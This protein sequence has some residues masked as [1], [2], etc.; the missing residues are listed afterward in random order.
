M[1][2]Y[3]F[4]IY[5]PIFSIYNTVCQSTTLYFNTRPCIFHSLN[6]SLSHAHPHKMIVYTC[7]GNRVC[8]ICAHTHACTHTGTAVCNICIFVWCNPVYLRI[9]MHM[10]VCVRVARAHAHQ[11]VQMQM[12][13]ANLVVFAYI[14]MRVCACACV[15]VHVC[16]CVCVCVCVSVYTGFVLATLVAPMGAMSLTSI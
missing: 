8:T 14:H 6:H 12:Y 15:R 2:F 7:Q 10:C 3:I 11:L 16:V 13:S 5:K 9:C 1:V 4:F